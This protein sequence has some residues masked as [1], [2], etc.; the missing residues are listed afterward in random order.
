[1]WRGVLTARVAALCPDLVRT[2]AGGSG[3]ISV[4]YVW[5]PRARIWQ[6]PERGDRFMAE[7]KEEQL[8]AT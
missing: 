2:W 3:P 5:H 4:R 7:F 6:G 8:P 1:M